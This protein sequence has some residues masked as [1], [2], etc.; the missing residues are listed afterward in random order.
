MHEERMICSDHNVEFLFEGTF[1]CNV[2]RGCAEQVYLGLIGDRTMTSNADDEIFVPLPLCNLGKHK[3]LH[4][5]VSPDVNPNHA[6]VRIRAMLNVDI[7]QSE[8]TW[9]N[10][11]EEHVTAR[12]SI[13]CTLYS[14]SVVQNQTVTRS[15]D[16]LILTLD[17]CHN[18]PG[19]LSNRVTV[20]KSLAGTFSVL[21]SLVQINVR[22]ARGS[23][24]CIS[25]KP[26]A[27]IAENDSI[28]I[29]LVDRSR[30][31]D[32]DSLY[33]PSCQVGIVSQHIHPDVLEANHRSMDFE[34]ESL[35]FKTPQLAFDQ[36]S[37]QTLPD[38]AAC[39]GAQWL[40]T[41][42]D[43]PEPALITEL[44]AAEQCAATSDKPRPRG[45]H[46]DPLILEQIGRQ[47][48]CMLCIN[49]DALI[50]MFD[51]WQTLGVKTLFDSAP[52]KNAAYAN[53]VLDDALVRIHHFWHTRLLTFEKSVQK[54]SDPRGRVI[55]MEQLVQQ[56]LQNGGK[57]A[58]V[59]RET[60]DALVAD[61]LNA[62]LGM[63]A[64]HK[65]YASDER[66]ECSVNRAGEPK[67][68]HVMQEYEAIG[69]QEQGCP[70]QRDEG[71]GDCEDKAV[72][73]AKKH[74][75]FAQSYTQL[76]AS[77]ATPAVSR[78]DAAARTAARAAIRAY[79]VQYLCGCVL[80][81]TVPMVTVNSVDLKKLDS[82][83]RKA[84]RRHEATPTAQCVCT[85]KR[86]YDVAGIDW[87]ATSVDAYQSA[88]AKIVAATPSNWA[89][90]RVAFQTQE[91][92]AAPSKQ[93]HSFLFIMPR[94]RCEALKLRGLV[95]ESLIQGK[96]ADGRISQLD[97]ASYALL[98]GT[99]TFPT[100]LHDGTRRVLS[101]R[102]NMV[103]APGLLGDYGQRHSI[104]LAQFKTEIK[105]FEYA[106]LLQFPTFMPD[107][108]FFNGYED[109]VQVTEATGR[110]V[111]AFRQASWYVSTVTTNGSHVSAN[112]FG[113]AT[114][115][116]CS[117]YS[118]DTCEPFQLAEMQN[119]QTTQ[120]AQVLAL[121]PMLLSAAV[122][123]LRVR[124]VPLD[125]AA[126]CATP[127]ED[128]T[129][130]RLALTRHLVPHR[131]PRSAHCRDSLLDEL[132]TDS[133]D[134]NKFR[135]PLIIR[136]TDMP[137]IKD[138][139]LQ[140]M[141]QSSFQMSVPI[142]VSLYDDCGFYRAWIT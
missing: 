122:P 115:R 33:D 121:R 8:P 39:T 98:G 109:S 91:A 30:G 90:S 130:G 139:L 133:F 13:V 9:M 92:R 135:F 4:V 113:V 44:V 114:R 59:T 81:A 79:P 71:A 56:E 58:G 31:A 25:I 99:C 125:F 69:D 83:Q 63:A 129:P 78:S 101:I 14:S 40:E 52:A 7:C 20:Q 105:A 138:S 10:F 54:P 17:M 70:S 45:H 141:Q 84:L 62:L 60:A 24:Q 38:L 18:T 35:F 29:S 131:M 123:F 36:T 26:T 23:G 28:A 48:M 27:K 76:F 42:M 6:S 57:P 132:P 82:F 5:A 96:S 136:C 120:L 106:N 46:V 2:F 89:N 86:L 112:R 127:V 32:G 47:L 94:A 3:G 41:V 75:Q 37:F 111:G 61:F 65:P 77:F 95:Y 140:F 97:E 102:P 72:E 80:S 124:K 103:E 104:R 118:T 73:A 43:W 119:S 51:P 117:R 137:Q 108:E 126:V 110:N 21:L 19:T 134:R 22:L 15:L 87:T 128:N 93:C 88:V 107:D 68:D 16:T 11:C 64:Y 66:D 85:N 74:K 142:R 1:S 116:M 100:I 55:G 34:N 67:K 12:H 50:R 53:Q 49:V